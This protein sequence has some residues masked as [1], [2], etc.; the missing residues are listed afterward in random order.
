MLAVGD[1][2]KLDGKVVFSSGGY[3][4]VKVNTPG[5]DTTITLMNNDDASK[6]KCSSFHEDSS[7]CISV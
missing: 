6:L 5:I 2:V 3:A 7:D 4:M 1:N